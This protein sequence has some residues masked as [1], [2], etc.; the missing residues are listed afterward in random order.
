MLHLYENPILIASYINDSEIGNMLLH[1]S[2]IY[3]TE[4]YSVNI[5]NSN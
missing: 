5:S 2:R 1:I 4:T 3:H